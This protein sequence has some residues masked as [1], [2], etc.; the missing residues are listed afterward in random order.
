MQIGFAYAIMSKDKKQELVHKDKSEAPGGATP[1]ASFPYAVEQ[2]G[3]SY[4]L[5]AAV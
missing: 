4:R 3:A 2:A 5:F 1:R